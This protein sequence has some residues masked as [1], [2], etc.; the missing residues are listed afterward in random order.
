MQEQ[1]PQKG[2]EEWVSEM[3]EQFKTFKISEEDLADFIH[4]TF[5][6]PSDG[7]LNRLQ[8]VVQAQRNKQ[9]NSSFPTIDPAASISDDISPIE[10]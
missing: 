7:L 9:L 10:E 4:Y 8:E 1:K 6:N 3:L 5:E 2:T